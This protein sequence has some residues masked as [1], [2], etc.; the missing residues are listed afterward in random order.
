MLWN[1]EDNAFKVNDHHL[2]VFLEQVEWLGWD[3]DLVELIDFNVLSKAQHK[4]IGLDYIQ[5]NSLPKPG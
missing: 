1:N 4:P 5:P 2:K 3:I